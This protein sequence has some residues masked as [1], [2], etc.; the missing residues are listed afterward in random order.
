[1]LSG[2]FSSTELLLEGLPDVEN[3]RTLPYTV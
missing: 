2:T 1:M 3:N